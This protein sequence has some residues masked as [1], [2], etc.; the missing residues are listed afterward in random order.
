MRNPANG[1][2]IATV[3]ASDVEDVDRAA[4]AASAA[5]ERWQHSTPQDRS[6]M[7]LRL[8]DAV[9][10][11][12]Q[13][14][15]R[16][17]SRNGGKPVGA[18]VDEVGAMVDNLRF[19]AGAARVMEGKAANEYVAGHTS[20]SAAIPSGWWPR[21]RRGTTR[22][23]WPAGRSARRWLPATPSSSSRPSAPR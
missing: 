18:A 22:S 6:L 11:R 1:E 10:A 2:V 19:F 3:P 21:S 16:L 4:S 14:L 17:E 13:E 20:S 23:T 7:L 8:A 15:G 12:A 5:F 9:E